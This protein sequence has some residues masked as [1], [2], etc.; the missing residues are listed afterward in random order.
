MIGGAAP[1]LPTMATFVLIHGA[2]GRAYLLCTDDRF[3][4]RD[5][6]RE[7]VRDRLGLEPDD[8]PGGH[9]AF[10]SQPG[11]LTTAIL[12]AWTTSR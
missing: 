8:V 3:Y 1:R 11:P 4:P 5:W 9:C 12:D 10:L 7:L 2:G 6:M